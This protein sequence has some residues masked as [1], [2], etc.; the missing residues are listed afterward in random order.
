MSPITDQPSQ[1]AFPAIAKRA[2]L[3]LLFLASFFYST[4]GFANWAAAQHEHVGSIVYDWERAIPF[5]AWT[6]I[7]Y[8]TINAFYA[9]SLFINRTTQG[10]DRLAGRYLT[11]QLIAVA[12]FLAFPLAASFTRPETSGLPGFMFDVLG[13]FDKPFNQA[14]SLHIAL[15]V[16]IWDHLRR[17]VSGAI[18]LAWHIWC[19]LIAASVLTTYQHHFIDIPTGALLGLFALWLFPADGPLPFSDVR[20]TADAKSRRSQRVLRTGRRALFARVNRRNILAVGDM[21]R[22]SMA[23]AGARHGRFRLFRGRSENVSEE[24][25][26]M[27]VAGEPLAA[28]ALSSWREDQR[29]GMDTENRPSGRDRR[30]RLAR[31]V[32][33]WRRG[34]P[35]RRRRRPCGGIGTAPGRAELV[36]RFRCWILS[37]PSQAMSTPRP[38]AV[39]ADRQISP[40][41]RS[42]CSSAAPSASNA[43]LAWS[44]GWLIDT[45]SGEGQVRSGGVAGKSRTVAWPR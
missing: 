11:A 33:L 12:C 37:R 31:A 41:K 42:R 5:L 10:V 17:R 24:R 7:P 8:W 25:R 2:A 39:E 13:G 40:G 16:I 27:C 15:T 32:S 43:A 38:D 19:F 36:A 34:R 6:I 35:L 29:M 9:V 4:Y 22:A 18:R 26:R 14:P 1:Q 28:V 21:A 20:W 30:R 44:R 23:G 3:W 45:G